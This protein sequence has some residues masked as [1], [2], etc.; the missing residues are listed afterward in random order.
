LA[1]VLLAVALG[2]LAMPRVGR[3]GAAVVA[4]TVGLVAWT[5]LTVIWSIVPDRSWDAFNKTVAYAAFLGLGLV[6]AAVAGRFGA[7]LGASL[8]A[9]FTAIV[10]LWGLLS[11]AM[12]ALDSSGGRIARLSEPV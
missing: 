3:S 4:A 5:G 12:P 11:K 10:L 2:H 7:R 1:G 8:L 6:L 9:L